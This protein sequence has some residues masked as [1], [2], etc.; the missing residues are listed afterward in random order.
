MKQC[1]TA[2][3]G[4]IHISQQAQH[5]L[6]AH[7]DVVEHLHTAI[8]KVRLPSVP[9]EITEVIDVG[10][11]IGRRSIVETAPLKIEERALFSIRANRA[12]PSRVSKAVEYGENTSKIVVIA[13]PS[14]IENQYELVTA[15]IGILAMKEPGDKSIADPS[16]FQE[17]LRFWSANAIVYDASCMG[18]VFESSWQDVL[19]LG[20]SQF[21]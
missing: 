16:E 11:I 5:H 8:C 6:K 17:C 4:I 14:L 12:L 7:P 1:K 3:G 21:L 9:K 2:C 19:T 13:R 18:P 15:W 20:K 10:K